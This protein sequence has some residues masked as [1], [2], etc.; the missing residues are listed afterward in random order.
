MSHL[1]NLLKSLKR[2]GSVSPTEGLQELVVQSE[3]WK[4]KMFELHTVFYIQILKNKTKIFLISQ[5]IIII[6]IVRLL[7]KLIYFFFPVSTV[8]TYF[9]LDVYSVYVLRFWAAE[10]QRQFFNPSQGLW[11]GATVWCGAINRAHIT[12]WFCGIPAHGYS[13]AGING[14]N[15]WSA[16]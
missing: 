10:L 14:Y 6:I 12:I 4:Q 8:L 11:C 5:Q 13:C 1:K 9:P 7:L 15:H 3:G 16:L 2:S